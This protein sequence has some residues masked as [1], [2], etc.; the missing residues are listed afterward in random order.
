MTPV[1]LKELQ[2]CY[3]PL[4][5]LRLKKLRASVL[6]NSYKIDSERVANGMIREVSSGQER[7]L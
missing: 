7:R 4:H 2:P 5:E 3:R 1:N 6:R